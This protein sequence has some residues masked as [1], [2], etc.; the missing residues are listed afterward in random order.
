MPQHYNYKGLK[1]NDLTIISIR[2]KKETHQE[3][4]KIA[5]LTEQPIA[6]IVRQGIELIIK[7]SKNQLTDINTAV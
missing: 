1:M 5:Y 7:K 4:R 6:E 3:L 2:M